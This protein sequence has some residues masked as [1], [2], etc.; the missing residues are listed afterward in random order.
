MLEMLVTNYLLAALDIQESFSC[1]Q[2]IL[3]SKTKGIPLFCLLSCRASAACLKIFAGLLSDCILPLNFLSNP[4]S[5]ACL[6]TPA[7]RSQE[8]I[9]KELFCS[10]CSAD[11]TEF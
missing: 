1:H 3:P 9:C 2:A 6:P 10:L 8:E 5:F 4:G 11:T 7:P